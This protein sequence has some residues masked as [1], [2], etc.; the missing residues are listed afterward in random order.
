M[1]N[2][3]ARHIL[4]LD[5]DGVLNIESNSYFTAKERTNHVEPHLVSRFNYLCEKTAEDNLD[6][7]I[8]SSWRNAM[9]ELEEELKG[10]GFKYWDRVIGKTTSN[11][12]ITKR[13]EQIQ[14]WLDDNVPELILGINLGLYILDDEM[15]G[16]DHLFDE[17]YLYLIDRENG[18]CHSTVQRILD[19]IKR[20]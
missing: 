18:L 5:V 3:H 13:G 7:V 1:E 10:V 9:G 6:I 12:N 14:R 15:Y 2:K 11:P 4:M 16:I 20:F 8:S 17:Q 19:S